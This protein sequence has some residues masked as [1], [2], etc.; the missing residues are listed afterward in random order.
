MADFKTM[1]FQL[2]N[3]ISDVIDLLQAAQQKMEELYIEDEEEETV[4]A[5]Q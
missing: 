4:A 2:F 1:Y 3:Q 5:R